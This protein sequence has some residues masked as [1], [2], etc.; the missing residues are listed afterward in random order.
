MEAQA[1]L[2]VRLQTDILTQYIGRN[3]IYRRLV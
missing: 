2:Q 1:E 3:R